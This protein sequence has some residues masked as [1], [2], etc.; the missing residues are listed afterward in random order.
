MNLI[1]HPHSVLSAVKL[2]GATVLG[3]TV[4]GATVAPHQRNNRSSSSG[5]QKRTSV[6]SRTWFFHPSSPGGLCTSSRWGWRRGRCPRCGHTTPRGRG[7]QTPPYGWADSASS[8]G[9]AGGKKKDNVFFY[10]FFLS[11]L[12]QW[13]VTVSEGSTFMAGGKL[14]HMVMTGHYGRN[15]GFKSDEQ[16]SSVRW[17]PV[18]LLR[19]LRVIH[20]LTNSHLDHRNSSYSGTDQSSLCR[21][22]KRSSSSSW[23]RRNSVERITPV[24]ASCPVQDPV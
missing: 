1:N 8:D 2:P 13:R 12:Q 18:L 7:G 11:S 21:S 15:S 23:R 14:L 5:G 9:P 3:A 17:R 10:C 19:T 20:A 6:S 16:L 4:L 24:L 22:Q